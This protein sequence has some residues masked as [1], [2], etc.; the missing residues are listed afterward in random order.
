MA[1][2]FCTKLKHAP[3]RPDPAETLAKS[4]SATCVAPKLNPDHTNNQKSISHEPASLPSDQTDNANMSASDQQHISYMR[5]AL[6]EA[7]KSP[8]KPT[9]YAVG[10]VLVA[11]TPENPILNT[12]Y[13]LECEGNTHA[14]QCCFIKQAQLPGINCA[15][16]QLGEYLPEGTVLY[17]T[18]EPC[19][20]R[21]AGNKT[22]V[23]RILGLK[24]KSGRQAINRVYIGA[25]EPGTFVQDNKG[26][27]RLAEVGIDVVLVPGMEQDILS[28]A[29][30][31]HKK[32]GPQNMDQEGEDEEDND[33]LGANQLLSA[34]RPTLG[35][36][37]MGSYNDF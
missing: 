10:A 25:T 11:P 37:R 22:C 30:A 14:E 2:T 34:A 31:G 21:S 8:P 17:T 5:L 36:M 9:N 7:K 27:Q 28:V 20:Q 18:M 26:R 35:N 3:S 6:A 12:G 32:P 24:S 4:R 29:T 19:S 1:T 13:T 23:E 16:E 33:E 15:E